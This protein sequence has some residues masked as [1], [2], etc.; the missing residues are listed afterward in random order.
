MLV[1]PAIGCTTVDADEC[2]VNT[3]GGF[4]GGGTIPI[5]NAVGAS[6]GDY[7]SRP[8]SRPPDHDATAN[9]CVASG[10][11]EGDGTSQE[12]GGTAGTG[13]GK[14]G[15][16]GL[17]PEEEAM[18]AAVDPQ[19]FAFRSAIAAYAASGTV[20]LVE[21]QLVDPAS[22]DAE[23]LR[24]LIESNAPMAIDDAKAWA[25]SVDPSVVP[26]GNFNTPVLIDFTCKEPPY[27]CD[28]TT[29]CTFP[30][31]GPVNCFLSHCGTGK[32]PWCPFGGNLV[33]KS[34]C[35]YGCAFDGN[36]V[37][38]AFRLRTIFN[39]WNGTW[40]VGW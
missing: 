5:G 37:G 4:G 26:T 3:S 15:A 39:N 25:A 19:E 14:P 21:S 34:W 32:C 35:S 30:G 13:D 6:S 29:S 12:P 8:Q 9:P 28:V 40:C 20:A 22:V 27:L 2:W 36:L 11:E 17:T 33:F 16:E 38:G 1:N 18:L 7:G 31:F 10:D 23:T 24:A